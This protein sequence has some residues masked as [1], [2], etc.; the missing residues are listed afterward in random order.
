V[1]AERAV[2]GVILLSNG[3]L[4][5]DV[6]A[7]LQADD[8]FLPSHR[9]IFRRMGGMRGPI[10]LVTLANALA[11]RSEL[12]TI[13]GATYL[14]SLTDGFPKIA[15]ADY[16]VE[17]LKGKSGLRKL[18][19][20]GQSLMTRSL[21]SEES[22]EQI[23]A[24]AQR[25]LSTLAQAGGGGFV[26]VPEVIE[27]QFGSVEAL[28]QPGEKASGIETGFRALDRTILGLREEELV[29]LAGRPGMG[30]TALALNIAAH[31]A[32]HD[33]A[34][35][36]FSLE[37]TSRALLVRLLC[38]EARVNSHRWAAGF[39]TSEDRQR[40]GQAA[41]MLATKALFFDDGCDL[42]PE[43]MAAR[44]K[45]HK[46]R[47]GLSLLIVDYLQLM[48][49][50]GHRHESRT[51]EI[52]YISR[53]MKE[54]AR[55]LKV[56]VLA[57]SQLNRAQEERGG[58]PR[59]SDLRESGQIEQ[60][61][62]VVLFLWREESRGHSHPARQSGESEKPADDKTVKLTVAK[63]RNGPVG[64]FSLV[65]LKEFCRFEECE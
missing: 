17:L 12:A 16:Y 28:F 52:S 35:G 10:D 6:A 38:S 11:V 36:I 15:N 34:V 65:F 64:S 21:E 39:A 55:E 53:A 14:S 32:K 42:R 29:I 58:C 37:M 40:L 54:M 20:A 60:D 51:Q 44:A 25:S 9:V 5:P 1:E 18:A 48:A 57:V 47:H 43:I 24:E 63:Q 30:K 50:G 8:F 26:S 56:P 46:Q 13:G 22:P 2:L 61:A 19:A 49:P 3:G 33:G 7:L 59:L 27:S 31:V 45:G 4:Y 62:D 23:L 41:G